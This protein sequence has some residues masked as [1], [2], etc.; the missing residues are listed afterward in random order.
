M[1][2]KLS[3]KHFWVT[4]ISLLCFLFGTFVHAA[5]DPVSGSYEVVRKVTAGSQIKVQL[6]FH[7]TN[8]GTTSLSLLSIVIADMAQPPKGGRLAA[9]VKLPPG[10]RE[11]VTQ[12]FVIPRTEYDQW[13]RGVHPRVILQLRTT[14]GETLTQAVRLERVMSEKGE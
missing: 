10:G 6:R 5:N 4:I 13:Q 8:R 1:Y 11:I 3:W 2:Q 7:L 9:P 12:E 14:G